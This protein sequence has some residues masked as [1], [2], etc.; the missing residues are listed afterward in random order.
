M[1][2]KIELLHESIESIEFPWFI[3][4]YIKPYKLPPKSMENAFDLSSNKVESKMPFY[5]HCEQKSQFESLQIFHRYKENN[6]KM[7]HTSDLLNAY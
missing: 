1:N 4:I 6:N 7:P 3:Y 5:L 2:V